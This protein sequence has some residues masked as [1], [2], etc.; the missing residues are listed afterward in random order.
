[1]NNYLAQLENETFDEYRLRT[2]K[3]KQLGTLKMTW[4]EIAEMFSEVWDVCRDEST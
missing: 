4:V 3:M 1:M 2:Y